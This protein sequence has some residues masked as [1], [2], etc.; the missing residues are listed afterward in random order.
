MYCNGAFERR[1]ERRDGARFLTNRHVDAIDILAFLVDDGVNSDGGFSGLTVADDEFA[2]AATDGNHRVDGFDSGL[3]RLFDTFALHH[4]G[5]AH[6]DERALVGDN[7]AFAVD[8]FA[9]RVDHAA[10]ERFANGNIGDAARGAN[11]RAF[12]DMVVIARDNHA[13]VVFFQIEGDAHRGKTGRGRRRKF[14]QL[15]R[16]GALQTVN[17]RDA[18]AHLENGA[19]IDHLQVGAQSAFQLALENRGN[20]FRS[21]CHVNFFLFTTDL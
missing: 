15:A 14:E 21:D 9:E 13:D 5:R 17:A 8:G 12:F 16:F 10:K 6:F 4:A 3:H 18:V 11:L 19:N 2:L 7:R 20:F 1:H